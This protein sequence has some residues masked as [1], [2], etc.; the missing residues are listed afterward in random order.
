MKYNI[1]P[2]LILRRSEV[3]RSHSQ[4]GS[5]SEWPRTVWESGY[6]HPWDFTMWPYVGR[7]NGVAIWT[8]L[9]YE[10]GGH[11][12]GVAIWTGFALKMYGLFDG[13]NKVAVLT[14][15]L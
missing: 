9:P 6:I 10:R 15:W 5:E 3:T 12:N 1:H 14:R 4:G 11:M 13:Q 7:I 2:S 8:G